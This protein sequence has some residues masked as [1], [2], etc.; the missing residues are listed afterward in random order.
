MLVFVSFLRKGSVSWKGFYFGKK[1]NSAVFGEKVEDGT[2]PR[3]A[4]GPPGGV[5]FTVS[6][7]W[8]SASSFER[9]FLAQRYCSSALKVVDW[10]LPSHQQTFCLG[11]CH[12]KPSSLVLV[13]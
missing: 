11:G 10:R 3:L 5:R 8:I 6:P 7:G 2:R 13:G 4:S 1:K 9:L 12:L